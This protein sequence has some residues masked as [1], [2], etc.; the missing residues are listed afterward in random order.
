MR[1]EYAL[2]G[3]SNYTAWKDHMEVV[4]E[5]NGLRDFIDQEFHKSVVANAQELAEWKKYVVRVRRILLEG[6]RDHIVSSIYGKE[7]LFS[8]WKTLKDL[9][10][11]NSD[12]RKLALKDKLRK[13]KK[14]EGETIPTYLEKFTQCRDEIRS[15]GMI[16][17]YDDLVSLTLICLPKS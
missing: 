16:V 9:Y 2:D 12:Q 5:D 6:V 14:E 13:I 11:N 10:Q 3:S 15:V 1:L 8:M 7:T 17:V 4:L